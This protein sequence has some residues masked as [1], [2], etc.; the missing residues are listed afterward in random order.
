[1]KKGTTLYIEGKLQT[2]EWEKDGV[3]RY[4]TEIVVDMGGTMKMM[5]GRSDSG[6]GQAQAKPAQAKQQSQERPAQAQPAPS[7]DNFDDD[8]PF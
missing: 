1:M 2:R 6:A 8:I 5:G 7:D 4:S 3:K